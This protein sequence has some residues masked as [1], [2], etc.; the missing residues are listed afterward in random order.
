MIVHLLAMVLLSLSFTRPAEGNRGGI[1]LD[2]SFAETNDD[3]SDM[4]AVTIAPKPVDTAASATAATTAAVTSLADALSGS[5]PTDPTGSLPAAVAMS[6]DVLE[7]RNVG[8]GASMPG[9]P[10]AAPVSIGGKA[11]V[12]F[13]GT[14]GDGY[15]FVFV[16]DRSG[17]MGGSGRNALEFAK[18]ALLTSLENL[19]PTHQFQIIFY[20]EQ[21]M[22]FNPTGDPDRLIFATDQ[23]KALARRFVGTV[24][25]EGGTRHEVALQTAIKLR[26]DVIFFLTDADEP[27]LW[28][29]ELNRIH[30]SA[31]G[32]AINSIEFGF[33]PQTDIDNFLVRLAT[34]NGGK[35]AYFNVSKLPSTGR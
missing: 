8:G 1:S 30:R 14:E 16:V 12:E 6:A 3:V 28:P 26:P 5:P 25:P 20:N 4:P 10:T 21:T 33:G 17:S 35:H 11:R 19:S 32:I 23:N 13:L 7:N 34:E 27:K 31:S 24:T 18:A 29:A 9:R 2:L 22:K 15:K